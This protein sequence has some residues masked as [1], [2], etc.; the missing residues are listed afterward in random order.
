M[1]FFFCISVISVEMSLFFFFGPYHAVGSLFSSLTRDW[2]WLCPL[3]WKHGDL[4]TELPGRCRHFLF[5]LGSLSFL[6]AEPGPR[7]VS[8]V[9][10]VKEPTL[11]F[12]DVFL[13]FF[14][15]SIY[16]LPGLYYFLPFADF[17]FCVM[18]HLRS[19]RGVGF[20]FVSSKP[21][22]VGSSR[23][24]SAMAL[25]MLMKRRQR[26]RW[27]SAFMEAP[28]LGSYIHKQVD[29]CSELR[30]GGQLENCM[31]NLACRFSICSIGNQCIS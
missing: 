19:W 10:P 27:A 17:R 18:V 3:Q 12:I 21:T 14:S 9:F 6:L 15:I 30:L 28:K 31:Q 25:R 1:I 4:T 13:L 26:S 20:L 29:G 23:L 11:G 24:W 7:F 16:F 5:Y 8:V 22:L 2:T